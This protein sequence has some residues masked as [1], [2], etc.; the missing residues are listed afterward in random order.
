MNL[1]DA[2]QIGESKLNIG[3]ELFMRSRAVA[4][5]MGVIPAHMGPMTL[6][7]ALLGVTKAHESEDMAAEMTDAMALISKAENEWRM[8][9]RQR[10]MH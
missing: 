5:E 1:N 10:E 9:M 3:R 7:L 6:C 8:E 4:K 2:R